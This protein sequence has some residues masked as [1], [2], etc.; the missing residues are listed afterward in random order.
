MLRVDK[1]LVEVIMMLLNSSRITIRANP[2]ESDE[3]TVNKG[4]YQASILIPLLIIIEAEHTVSK[5]LGA[6]S[7]LD[8]RF[9]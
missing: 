6:R 8:F 7:M 3:L 2:L 5:M 9:S 4:L 1:C